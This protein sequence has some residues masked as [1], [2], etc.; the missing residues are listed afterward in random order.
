MELFVT[1][2]TGAAAVAVALLLLA[3]LVYY[4]RRCC[5]PRQ[6]DVEANQ[7]PLADLNRTE[8]APR[9]PAAASH[10]V[11]VHVHQPH[12][13]QRHRRGAH[14]AAPAV[15]KT[16]AGVPP[17]I[18]LHGMSVKTALATL[19]TFLRREARDRPR[20]GHV[21]V[22][23]G[24]GLHSAGGVAKIRPA[25]VRELEARGLRFR[26]PPGNTGRINVYL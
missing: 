8:P 10:L 4:I 1:I 17:T 14:P 15:R 13:P 19:D 7:H 5:R 24:R 23:T 16:A 3:L 26:S 21:C 22:I 18:D 2:L 6:H 9:L 20:A 25:V 12:S 11:R